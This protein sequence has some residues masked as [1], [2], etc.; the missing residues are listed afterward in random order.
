MTAI[1]KEKERGFIMPSKIRPSI[2]MLTVTIMILFTATSMA[3]V[4]WDEPSCQGWWNET[5]VHASFPPGTEMQNWGDLVY[6]QTFGDT[7]FSVFFYH[8]DFGHIG[9]FFC[10]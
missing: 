9:F 4:P 5:S 1:R 2:L 7:L 10:K 6:G 3:W 8:G